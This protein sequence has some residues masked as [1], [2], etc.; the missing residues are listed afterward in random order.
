MQPMETEGTRSDHIDLRVTPQEKALLMQ[1]ATN[2]FLDVDRF[3]LQIAIKAAKKVVDQAEYKLSSERDTQQNV[4]EKP[5]RTGKDLIAFFRNS[6][7]AEA[8][9]ELDLERDKSTSRTITF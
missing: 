5:K 7:L 4:E 1:A 2:E 3:I 6:P 9:L 8:A